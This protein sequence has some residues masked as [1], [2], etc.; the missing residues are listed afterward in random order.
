MPVFP[1]FHAKH[2]P[3][4]DC[5]PVSED[6][7][8]AYRG[9]LP[10]ELIEEWQEHGWCAYQDGLLWTID[11]GQLADVIDDG[12]GRIPFLR[13]AFGSVFYWD[14]SR[15]FKLDAFTG[16]STLVFNRMPVLFDSMLCKADYLQDSLHADLFQ[17][18]LAERGK[19]ARDE[20]Y[21]YL[22]PLPMGGPGTF[23]T[24]KRVKLREHLAIVLQASA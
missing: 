19:L 10:D 13:T 7:C 8:A 20:C 12:N 3:A 11:P 4:F 15:A 23:E 1:K 16:E 9:K 2:G 6:R 21:G 5:Q 17:H 22:P 14:G 18:A 24:L